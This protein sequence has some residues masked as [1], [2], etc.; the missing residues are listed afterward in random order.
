MLNG[1]DDSIFPP[2]MVNPWELASPPP[3]TDNP[4]DAHVDVAVPR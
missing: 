2:V 1:A 4:A 3:V